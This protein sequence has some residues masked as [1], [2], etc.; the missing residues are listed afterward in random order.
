MLHIR[1]SFPFTEIATPLPRT[2]NSTK[3]ERVVKVHKF[4][5]PFSNGIERDHDVLQNFLLYII[6]FGVFRGGRDEGVVERKG[7]VQSSTLYI[8]ERYTTL[9]GSTM[10]CVHPGV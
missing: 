9:P 1:I 3:L 10:S 4:R 6:I 5:I 8:S 2:C 7:N